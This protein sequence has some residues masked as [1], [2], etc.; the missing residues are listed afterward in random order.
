MGYLRD[1]KYPVKPVETG[2][3]YLA[4]ERLISVKEELISFAI[5][6]V[7]YNEF[8]LILILGGCFFH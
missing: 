5:C 4:R 2:G 1:I 8:L 3:I 7:E 6:S